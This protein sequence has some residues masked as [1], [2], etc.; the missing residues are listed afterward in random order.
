MSIAGIFALAGGGY[1]NNGSNGDSNY[2]F[3]GYY[4]SRG[5]GDFGEYNGY[6]GGEEKCCRDGNG[7]LLGSLLG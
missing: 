7:G 4:G 3:G 6:N 1:D 5:R 2:S